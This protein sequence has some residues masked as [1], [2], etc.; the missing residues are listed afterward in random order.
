LFHVGKPSIDPF[1]SQNLAEFHL[2]TST[3][4]PAFGGAL[5]GQADLQAPVQ[6]ESEELLSKRKNPLPSL[7]GCE[8]FPDYYR[9]GNKRQEKEDRKL[10]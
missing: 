5:P 3:L 8:G 6:Q 2:Q 4:Q 1:T 9:K 10:E 7:N